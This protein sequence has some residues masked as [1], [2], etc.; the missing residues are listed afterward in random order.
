MSKIT[1]AKCGKEHDDS[2]LFCPFCGKKR[3]AVRELTPFTR[4]EWFASEAGRKDAEQ[5][6]KDMQ[7]MSFSEIVPY[8]SEHLPTFDVWVIKCTYVHVV[9][10]GGPRVEVKRNSVSTGYLMSVL[11]DARKGLAVNVLIEPHRK[12]IGK[13]DIPALSE[14]GNVFR[15]EKE[16]QD[17]I[18]AVIDKHTREGLK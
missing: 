3:K 17:A 12:A 6:W 13:A 2:F 11:D 7:K 5:E 15:T 10:R 16:C 18:D 9:N 1:C 14:R 8:L 4:L